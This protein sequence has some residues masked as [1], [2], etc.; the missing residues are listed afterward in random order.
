MGVAAIAGAALLA[1]LLGHAQGAQFLIVG[2]DAEVSGNTPRSV[3][4]I[5]D[6]AWTDAGETIDIDIVVPEPGIPADRGLAAYQFRLFYDREIVRIVADESD[7]LL[8]QAAGSVLIPLADAKPNTSG[9]YLSSAVDFGPAGIEPGGSSEKGPGVLG[10]VTLETLKEGMTHLVVKDIILKDDAGDDIGVDSVQGARI[11]VGEPCPGFAATPT[12]SAGA[13]P[14]PSPSPA[15]P[16]PVTDSG[17]GEPGPGN[18]GAGAGP[19]EEIVTAGG[20]TAPAGNPAPLVIAGVLLAAAGVAATAL[21]VR[22]PVHDSFRVG[23]GAR[24][25]GLRDQ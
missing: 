19:P 16:S 4:D 2:I 20:P 23:A 7:Q 8:A 10:R 17:V 22:G 14:S 11:Y 15:T 24:S 25:R 21:A 18:G 3:F 12:L 6:C 1:V 5:D 13:T 9:V